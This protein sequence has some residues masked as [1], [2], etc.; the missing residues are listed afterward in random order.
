MNNYCLAMIEDGNPV[1][2]VAENVGP[3]ESLEAALADWPG[4]H[5]ATD[6]EY[7]AYVDYWDRYY[8]ESAGNSEPSTPDDGTIG[9]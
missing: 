4:F 6:D 8:S 7:A 5:E 1:P 3:Y 2:V 9:P